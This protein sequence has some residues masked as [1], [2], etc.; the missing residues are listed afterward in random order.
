M[1]EFLLNSIPREAQFLLLAG[2]ILFAWIAGYDEEND[3]QDAVF[4]LISGIFSIGIGFGKFLNAIL[5]VA[6]KGLLEL[7]S[8]LKSGLQRVGQFIDENVTI[9]IVFGGEFWKLVIIVFLASAGVIGWN[10]LGF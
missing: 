1:I 8:Q 9:Q 7:L 2:G 4:R 5:V 6:G 10:A 3:D